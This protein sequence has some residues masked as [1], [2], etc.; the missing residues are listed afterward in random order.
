MALQP[1]MDVIFP[2][3]C[4]LCGDGLVDH[5][6]LCAACWSGLVIP[7]SPS[8][9][10]CQRPFGEKNFQESHSDNLLCAP[11]MVEAPKHDGV[12]AGTV[13]NAVSRK[14][15]LAFKHGGR[16]TLAPLLSR[17]IFA[18]LNH[19]I[20]SRW[21]RHWL[22]VPVPLHRWR[23]WRRGY[24]QSALLGQKLSELSGAVL[25]VDGLQR[26]RATPSLAGLS[27]QARLRA[28]SGAIKTN[29]ARADMFKGAHIILV[30]D[31]LTTGATSNACISA[32]KRAGAEKVIGACASRVLD[33]V[34]PHI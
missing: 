12:A 28:L 22:V 25:V 14:L 13:Y 11:C 6:G 2:P 30:D 27:H 10:L 5:Q 15:V 18:R 3:R 16:I 20:G 23:L 33:E 4:P 26:H 9:S 21:D 17:L 32:L 29:S 19:V 7:A 8:C 31:V 24:N 34:W 1:L